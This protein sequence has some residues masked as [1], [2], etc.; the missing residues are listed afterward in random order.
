MPV[1]TVSRQLGSGGSY[2]ATQVARE[3]GLRYLDREI[4]QRAAEIAEGSSAELEAD[5]ERAESVPDLVNR[6]LYALASMP[7]IPLVPSATLREPP[8]IFDETTQTWVMLSAGRDT[9]INY[10]NL[11]R[12]VIE[13][14][15]REGN[16]I[17]VGRGGHIVLADQPHVFRVLIIAPFEQRVRTVMERMQLSERQAIRRVEQSDRERA[18]YLKRYYGVSWLDPQHFDLV[19]NTGKISVELACRLICAAVQAHCEG[20]TVA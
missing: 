5:L 9:S 13:E 1:I 6:I 15:A 7:T 16:A 3:L 8:Y 10:V 20:E 19:I 2:I 12:R 14:F 11:I 4:V 18:E 17:I